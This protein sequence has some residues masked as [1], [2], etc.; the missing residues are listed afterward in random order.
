MLT[1][2]LNLILGIWLIISSIAVMNHWNILVVGI[3]IFIVGIMP[4]FQK[5]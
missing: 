2:W 5:K 3:I 1:N 4:I